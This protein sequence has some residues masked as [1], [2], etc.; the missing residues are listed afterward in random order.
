[1]NSPGKPLVKGSAMEAITIQ[2]KNPLNEGILFLSPLIEGICVT[3]VFVVITE[4]Q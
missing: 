3:P 4:P 1:M 2:R